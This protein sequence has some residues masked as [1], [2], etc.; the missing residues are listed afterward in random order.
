M[1]NT[2]IPALVIAL[3]ATSLTAFATAGTAKTNSNPDK[4]N[5]GTTNA[6]DSR[7]SKSAGGNEK[8]PEKKDIESQRDR[9]IQQQDEQWLHDLQNL[10]N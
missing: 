7:S 5:C 2:I 1:K 9:L 10:A 8:Q 6:A 3:L 4:S